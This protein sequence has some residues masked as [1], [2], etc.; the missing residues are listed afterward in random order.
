MPNWCQ[1]ELSVRADES[2]LIEKIKSFL[3]GKDEDGE[4]I[5]IDFNKV[6]PMPAEL[7]GTHAPSF[8]E[9]DEQ[10]AENQRLIE[11]YGFDN[12]YDWRCE[13]WGTKWNAFHARLDYE[14]EGELKYSFGTP[15]V[16]P[17]GII[18][19]LRNKFPDADFTLFYR[20]DAM[21]ISGYI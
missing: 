19:A 20:E 12:W 15:W 5:A 9:T 2:A 10:K 18:K 16:P 7:D 8:N 14:D 3:S 4:D 21:Q 6:L 13:N 1:N 17:E 11:A